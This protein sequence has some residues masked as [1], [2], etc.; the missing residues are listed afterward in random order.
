M[1]EWDTEG[2]PDKAQQPPERAGRVEEMKGSLSHH[3]SL[4]RPDRTRGTVGTA[5]SQSRPS[6]ARAVRQPSVPGSVG[7]SAHFLPT[8]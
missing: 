2:S 7:A 6:G 1:T 3:G 5:S 8:L 4:E